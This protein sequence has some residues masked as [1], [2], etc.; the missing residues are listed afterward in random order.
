MFSIT[1]IKSFQ[2][3]LGS[4]PKWNIFMKF[5]I[6]INDIKLLSGDL[7]LSVFLTATVN[8]FPADCYG[9]LQF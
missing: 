9:E 1:S 5:T 7:S 6:I 4:A 2:Y 3:I 8:A